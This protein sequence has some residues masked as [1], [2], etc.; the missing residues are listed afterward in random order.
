MLWLC[1][2]QL[3]SLP[4]GIGKLPKLDWSWL[5]LSSAFDNNPLEH[6]PL[7]V[8]KQGPEA[9]EKY[10]SLHKSNINGHATKSLPQNNRR[11]YD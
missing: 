3:R 11:G 1:G 9:I 7:S 6:P 8:A 5:G 10:L 4:K 2:N